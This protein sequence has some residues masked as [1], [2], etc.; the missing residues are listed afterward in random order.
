MKARVGID[1]RVGMRAGRGEAVE[2]DGL[3]KEDK[4]D[5]RKRGG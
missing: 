5:E 4:G 2:R 3:G 1:R